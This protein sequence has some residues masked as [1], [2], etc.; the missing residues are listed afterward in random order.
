ME[1]RARLSTGKSGEKE[2]VR[3]KEKWES[4]CS[5]G[6]IKERRDKKEYEAKRIRIE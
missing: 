6:K 5:D 1:E 2:Q 3:R 4:P